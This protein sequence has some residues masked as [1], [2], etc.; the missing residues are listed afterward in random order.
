[1][2]AYPGRARE[3]GQGRDALCLN[4]VL[5]AV[6]PKPATPSGFT[7]ALISAITGHARVGP[8]AKDH[9]RRNACAGYWSIAQTIIAAMTP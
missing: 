8:S 3:A 2:S 7:S 4:P 9:L 5:T 1:M 6:L